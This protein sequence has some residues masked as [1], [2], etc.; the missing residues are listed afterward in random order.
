[1]TADYDADPP[2]ATRWW[3]NRRR[4]SDQE[5]GRSWPQAETYARER[6][7]PADE[8]CD[9]VE[10]GADAVHDLLEL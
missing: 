3:C 8:L 10:T 7:R 4:C 2:A 5:E 1:M 6:R 9:R